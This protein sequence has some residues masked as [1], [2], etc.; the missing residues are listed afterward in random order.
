MR[1]F[2]NCFFLLVSCICVQ[3][4][5]SQAGF[6]TGLN[7]TTIN[8]PC[9]N[10]CNN[11]LLKF[12]HLKSP[13]DYTLV[14]IPYTPSAYTTP[15]GTELTALYADDRY[16]NLITMGFPFCFY[17]S[18][19][20]SVV[21]GSNGLLTFDASQANTANSWNT[22]QPIPFAG[23]I[24]NNDATTY[25]PP[26]SVMAA[27]T[28]LYPITSA[29]PCGRKIE[30]RVQ[31]NAPFRQFI[32]SY[33]RVGTFGAV[34]CARD[35][36]CNPRTPTTF[37]IVLYEQTGLIDLFIESKICQSTTAQGKAIMGIQNWQ[38]NKA[39]AG[40]GRNAVA[41]WT[42]SNEGWRFVPSGASSRFVKA[43]IYDLAG[44]LLQTTTPADT[45]TTT[46]GLLDVNFS[47][48]CFTGA[49]KQFV[50]KGY[51]SSCPSGNP[52]VSNDTITVVKGNLTASVSSTA[53][54][55][56]PNGTATITMP[57]GSSPY[58]FTIGT[59][60]PVTSTNNS[61][62]FTGLIAGTYTLTGT[63]SSGCSATS[64][65]TVA[66]NGS[67]NIQATPIAPTCSGINNGSI[68]VNPQNGT[69]PF[70]Y[71]I[72]NGASQTSNIFSSLAP[73]TYVIGARDS[74]GCVVA[75]H[76]VNIGAAAPVTATVTP[77]NVSCN[78]GNNG[79]VNI[80]F[81]SIALPLQYSL[82]GINYQSS[83][84]FG[85]LSAGNYTA[86]FRDANNCGGN[87]NFAIS[88]PS[89][90]T[91][92]V[93]KTDAV[94]DGGNGRITIT[95]N[96]GT[97]A[98]QYSI[99]GTTYQSSN[100]FIVPAGTYTAYVRDA[101]NC[102][103]SSS[104]TINQPA[105]LTATTITGN[106]SCNGG[107]DGK[108]TVTASGGTPGYQYSTN[109]TVFQASNIFNVTQGTFTVTIKD[110]NGC[111]TTANTTVGLTNNLTVSLSADTTI[112]EGTTATLRVAT[113]ATQVL[114]SSA[115]S[116]SDATSFSPVAN[117]KDTTEY[118]I[119]ATLGACTKKDSLVVSVNPAPLADAGINDE[120]CFGQGYTLQG[121]GGVVYEWSPTTYFN[122]GNSS[123]TQN[124]VITPSQTVTYSLMV[125]DAR[126]CKALSPASVTIIV[127]PPIKVD[128]FPIDTVVARGDV[129]LLRANSPV[130][131]YTW[132][133]GF[134][135][136]NAAKQNPM[137]TIDSDIEYLVTAY[138][139]A[140]CKGTD[141][142][143][144]KVYNGPE[145]YVPTAF[146]P[147]GDGRNEILMP[148]P[149][150]IKELKFF[151]VYN[152]W[153][154]PVFETKTL[155]HGWDGK[156]GGVIQ[157]MATYVWVLEAVTKEN[158][159]IKKRGTTTLIR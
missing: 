83:N 40:I 60:A 93:T 53:A 86:Y 80:L 64:T 103:V 70:Q 29:S 157:P 5:L 43:E 18:T 68:V 11:L 12:P 155:S 124:P 126:G 1:F 16:S 105:A 3:P 137:A 143:K 77:T 122:S 36:N 108:I 142:V 42:A 54:G 140:G 159:L 19:Y 50:V 153:G 30:W 128:A 78:G 26:A 111:I 121:N 150:G 49:S 25:Y 109:G 117:P 119:T 51:F 115:G 146:T 151:R 39:V 91:L 89:V 90:L 118:V 13:S 96:G 97:S 158:K 99:D 104:V 47:N 44:V 71:N 114:W 48:I 62:T 112:C 87:Q 113:N 65:I 88:Q 14:S 6:F 61:Y 132:S 156:L 32:A 24:P 98:Y 27:F 75:N 144:I 38:R 138:T 100:S 134:G 135:L 152:R 45:T 10:N 74:S 92:V 95:A 28:D 56:S 136:D 59:N 141:T 133:P 17:D 2:Y 101:A 130:N 139:G 41:G 73:G 149:V 66:L 33:Y 67:L 123:S 21:I 46:Q 72:N 58:T 120:V 7:G 147:N 55:C 76:V 57:A 129:I 102:I 81:S 8:V 84:T 82:D 85:G 79:S 52:L 34:S 4:V 20:N 131:D 15:T 22:I 63:N 23:G 9:G 69:P 31:G 116:L 37:Q 107:A 125:T 148:F 145:I 106:A 35:A 110:A 154:Q 94:C 127:T